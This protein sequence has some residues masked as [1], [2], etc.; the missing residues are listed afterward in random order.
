ME[1]RLLKSDNGKAAKVLGWKPE[2]S[3]EEGLRRTVEW[4]REKKTIGKIHMYQV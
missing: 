1:V 2:H 4:V 3:L